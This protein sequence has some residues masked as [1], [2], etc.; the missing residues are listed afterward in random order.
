MKLNPTKLALA[1][2]LSLGTISF[3]S[4]V[5]AGIRLNGSSLT[6]HLPQPNTKQQ[7]QHYQALTANGSSLGE[8]TSK[9]LPQQ[10]LNG[11]SLNVSSLSGHL[12]QPPTK[13]IVLE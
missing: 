13:P 10:Q 1:A 12:P 2:G 5:E 7:P 3:A 11:G 8:A 4:I 9:K 6:S